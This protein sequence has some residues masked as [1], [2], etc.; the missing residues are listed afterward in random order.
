LCNPK[1]KQRELVAVIGAPSDGRN[2]NEFVNARHIGGQPL[3]AGH[4]D[5]KARFFWGEPSAERASKFLHASF[6]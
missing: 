3:R 1:K 4:F 2:P 5:P 6:R